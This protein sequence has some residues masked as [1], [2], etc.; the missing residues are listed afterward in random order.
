M[1]Y[2]QPFI[3]AFLDLLKALSNTADPTLLISAS[4]IALFFGLAASCIAGAIFL[5]VVSTIV[6]LAVEHFVPALLAHKEIPAFPDFDM[7]LLHK[8]VAVYVVMLVAGGVVFGI[9]KA[10]LNLFNK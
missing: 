9:K 1:E 6:Y 3:D 7:A 2:V 4:V 8:A 10:V 5:P